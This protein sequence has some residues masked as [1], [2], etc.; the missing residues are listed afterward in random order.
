MKDAFWA[1]PEC[2][3]EL[4]PEDERIEKTIRREMTRGLR[5][6]KK[7]GGRGTKKKYKQKKPGEK[8]IPWWAR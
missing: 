4:W 6:R 5:A 1:C 2:G 8:F 3:A 7:G